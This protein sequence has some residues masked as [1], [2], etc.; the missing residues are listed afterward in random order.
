MTAIPH[1]NVLEALLRNE[2]LS[3]ETVTHIMDQILTAAMPSTQAAGL[4]IALRAKGE[5][6]EEIAAAAQA[7]RK[8]TV[9]VPV[10]DRDGL[11][12]T[13]G[14]GGDGQHTFN[15][16]TASAI[17]AAAA[18]AR[19]AKHAGRSVSSR[20]GSADL[21]E[22]V[23]VNID[24]SPQQVADSVS[25][26]GLGFFFA[27]NFNPAMRTVAPLRKELGVR[28]LFNMLGP[29]L[30]PANAGRQLLGVF[31][32]RLVPVFAQVLCQLGA[33]R[34]LVVHGLDG[35]D[36][37]T[38]SGPTQ[39][40]ELSDGRIREYTLHPADFGLQVTKLSDIQVQDVAEAKEMLFSVL[41]NESGPARDIVI[42]NSAA[43]IY[44]SGHAR[45]LAEGAAAARNT[46]ATGAA[47]KK[48]DDLIKFTEVME[49][50]RGSAQGMKRHG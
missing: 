13:C 35:L 16:S 41:R 32:P 44:L 24:L 27:P 30:N 43:V 26:L 25:R 50:E 6:V 49:A 47:I 12:D 33:S 48:L 20:C 46:L 19:I 18:G 31:S 11:V 14:T 10:I 36:E 29:L 9:P 40:A 45:S 4:L 2:N 34:A 37:I 3:P 38:I 22:A 28:T 17:V 8:K 42:M 21:L 7:L 23:G 15:I 39:V 5:T 1:R